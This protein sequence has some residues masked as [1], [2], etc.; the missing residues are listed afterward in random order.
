VA[1]VKNLIAK[2]DA[3]FGILRLD[4]EP[5]DVPGLIVCDDTFPFPRKT[6]VV[7]GATVEKMTSGCKEL[8]GP[9]V[10]AAQELEREGVVA[11]MGEC[12][13][14]AL[15][16]E[17]LQESVNVPVFTSSLLLVPLVSK[18]IPKGKRVGILTFRS[19]QLSEEHFR[20][21]GWSSREI[22]IA[23]AGVE[24]KSAWHLVLTPEHAYHGEDLESQLMEVSKRLIRNN[25]DTGALVLECAIMPVFAHRLQAE[26]DLPVFDITTL[27]NLVHESFSRKPFVRKQA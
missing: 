6:K 16:Q 23:V 12:G 4:T 3:M 25:P 8:Q 27:A 15:F 20:G 11:I 10:D 1:Y 9:M 19:D 18:M 17:V 22:P 21:A 24:D 14:M 2:E 5:L 13:F 26:L 7:K